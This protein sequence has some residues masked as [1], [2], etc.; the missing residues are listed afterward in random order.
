MNLQGSW[1]TTSA[2]ITMIIAGAVG[3]YFAAK[4]NVLNEGAITGAITSILGGVGLLFAKDKNVTGGTVI[5][6]TNDSSVV[7]TSTK[8]DKGV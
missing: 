7:A 2:G 8:V 5:N 3:I 1:K 6:P 4:N